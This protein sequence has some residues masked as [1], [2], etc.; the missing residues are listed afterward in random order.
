MWQ[1][2]ERGD[3]IWAAE[4]RG[5]PGEDAADGGNLA[6]PA[7]HHAWSHRL[8]LDTTYSG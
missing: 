5:Q 7:V 1:L 4:A 2:G 6:L 8:H 3:R